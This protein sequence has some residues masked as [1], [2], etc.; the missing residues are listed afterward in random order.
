LVSAD[1]DSIGNIGIG[2]FSK[3][4]FEPILQKLLVIIISGIGFISL[5]YRINFNVLIII[6]ILII[7]MFGEY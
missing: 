4:I 7:L 6:L 3:P 2:L 5:W 1:I